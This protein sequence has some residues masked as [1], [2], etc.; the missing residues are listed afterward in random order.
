MHGLINRAI[1]RFAEETQ[2]GAVWRAVL[3][4][5]APE[6][7]GFEAMLSYD[8]DL[9]EAVLAGLCAR[10]GTPREML[11]E[12]LGTFLVS[13]PSTEALRRLLRFGGESFA[14]FLLSLEDL[15]DRARLA[16]PD[17]DLPQ[18]EAAEAAPGQF[19]LSV[20]GG[21]PGF[22]P[23]LIGLLRAM[24][25]DY[26]ALALVSVAG[27]DD[28]GAQIEVRVAEVAYAEGRSFELARRAGA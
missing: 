21:W 12:D 27:Q 19:R 5:V 11:L 7:E 4:E 16:V 23:V 2:G 13:H 17:L 20:A 18:I 28:R 14:D 9:T 22:V 3:D 10:T 26:G 25:D 15:P 8:D 24:A 1:Q 6:L